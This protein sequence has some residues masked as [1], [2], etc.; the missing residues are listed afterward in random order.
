MSNPH[1]D[2][3]PRLEAYIDAARRGAT[4][5]LLL[6]SHFDDVNNP[7]SNSATC[8]YVHQVAVNE[9]LRL[10]CAL[11]NPAG[12]GIHNK[13]ILLHVGGRGW[14]LVGS[15][16]G[17]EQSTKGNREV[18]LQ[19]QSDTAYAYLA[20]LFV[21]D[22]PHINW[23]PFAGSNFHG[24]RD[25]PLISE[26]LYDPGGSDE[27]EFIEISNPTPDPVDLSGWTISDAVAAEDFEDSRRFPTG[28]VLGPRAALVV[29]L[30]A[31]SFEEQFGFLPDFEILNSSDSVT[32]L[33]DDPRWG[34][35]DAILQLGN[36]G[37][38]ILLRSPEGH[39]VDVVTYGAGAYVG[40]VSCALVE[41]AGYTLERLPYWHDSDDCSADFRSW[42]FP[43][44]GQLPSR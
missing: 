23:L 5:R 2:P 12:L 31:V 28:T 30:S 10:R 35:P 8:N 11:A 3:N 44:P 13:M 17:T 6:D 4:V 41:T 40:V 20:S 24:P 32:D 43:S 27:A 29:A 19:L 36:E 16:N 26:F 7:L 38:E 21:S 1:T 42:P 25:Y 14:V 22:W 33:P 18:Q 39:V 15:W 9:H 34:D 37:D